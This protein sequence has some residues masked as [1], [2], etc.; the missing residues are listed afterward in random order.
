MIIGYLDPWG[1]EGQD[2]HG[3]KKRMKEVTITR[4]TASNS[5]NDSCLT[6]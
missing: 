6:E 2:N 1:N 5:Q 4:R 3:K